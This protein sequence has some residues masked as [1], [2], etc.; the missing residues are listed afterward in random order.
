MLFPSS[1]VLSPPQEAYAWQQAQG[2]TP[3]ISALLSFSPLMCWAGRQARCASVSPRSPC[4]IGWCCLAS[5]ANWNLWDVRK[6]SPQ[7]SEN[8]GYFFFL[9]SL[10]IVLA[11]ERGP[12]G[13]QVPDPLIRKR[14]G[15]Q[16]MLGAAAS[17]VGYGSLASG[18]R[19]M[20]LRDKFPHYRLDL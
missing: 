2:V 12:S 5:F 8:C 4:K 18:L 13:L 14:Q 20:F 17:A 11:G 15:K 1:A 10:R 19:L 7:Q 3:Q 6:H 16:V 9:F